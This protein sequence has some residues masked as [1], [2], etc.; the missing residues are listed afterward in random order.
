MSD[1]ALNVSEL[2]G[3]ARNPQL[4]RRLR[5]AAIGSGSGGTAALDTSA[6]RMTF[7]CR[8][9][10]RLRSGRTIEVVGEEPGACGHTIAEQSEVV[11][12]KCDTVGIPAGLA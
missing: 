9:T 8:L 5:R 10:L 7:P 1:L 4:L 11:A 2:G 3:L 12:R 6:L